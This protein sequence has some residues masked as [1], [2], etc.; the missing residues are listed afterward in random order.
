M[1]HV[2]DQVVELRVNP[3][4]MA[5]VVQ[6]LTSEGMEFEY[7]GDSLYFYGDNGAGLRDNASLKRIRDN[8]T[9]RQTSKTCFL[10]LTGRGLREG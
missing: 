3:I 1:K 8:T 7:G 4:H 6:S 9:P 10:R 2:G 5:G